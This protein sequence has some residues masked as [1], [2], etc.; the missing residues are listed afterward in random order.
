M[1]TLKKIWI[2]S[3]FLLLLFPHFLFSQNPQLRLGSGVDPSESYIFVEGD[4]MIFPSYNSQAHGAIGIGY[5]HNAYFGIGAHFTKVVPSSV[6]NEYSGFGLSYRFAYKLFVCRLDVGLLT[7]YQTWDEY[8]ISE[9]QINNNPYCNAFVGVWVLR[10]IRLGA[11]FSWVPPTI[12]ATTS[13]YHGSGQGPI[14]IK[15]ERLNSLYLLPS[16][17]IS[18]PLRRRQ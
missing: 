8:S 18:I 10:V 13:Y 12:Q 4:A 7:N 17:G 6:Y 2:L 15:E 11:Y 1:K 16:I 5:Q 9:F 14:D 3:F